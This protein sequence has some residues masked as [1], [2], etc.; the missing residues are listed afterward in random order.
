MGAI[1]WQKFTTC[2]TTGG[3]SVMGSYPFP[4]NGA[5]MIDYEFILVFKKLG[6]PPKISPELKESARMT[7]EQ[8]VEYFSGH[9]HVPGER[10]DDH[11][12]TFPA[13]IP[14]RLIRMY[15]FP[16]EWVLDPFLGSGTTVKV[17]AEEG[18]LGV[19]YEIN[20][21]F[22]PII[23]RKLGGDPLTLDFADGQDALQFEFHLRDEADAT[24][25]LPR[26]ETPS[27][28]EPVTNQVRRI[29]DP[30]AYDFGS[31]IDGRTHSGKLLVQVAGEMEALPEWPD[32]TERDRLAKIVDEVVAQTGAD[33]KL[34]IAGTRN[35]LNTLK[36]FSELVR[37]S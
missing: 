2:N 1:I 5:I 21:E 20:P 22:R 27:D 18:R 10:Q 13:E 36:R 6:K 16:G 31:K 32:L 17:A 30:K 7:H 26:D 4:R 15:S 12:A 29:A 23:E 9:W 8:W 33:R 28:A 34:V 19:G 3:G 24:E 37:G 35:A 14:R 25:P 11:L